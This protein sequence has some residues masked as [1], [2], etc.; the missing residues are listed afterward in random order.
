MWP[1]A[2]ALSTDNIL[3]CLCLATAC[4]RRLSR[5]ASSSAPIGGS[6]GRTISRAPTETL[7]GAGGSS[8][9]GGGG[10]AAIAGARDRH[11]DCHRPLSLRSPS[12][13]SSIALLPAKDAT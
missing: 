3:C 7:G 4:C 10:G 5:S 11:I 8:S 12:S 1:V 6:R 9:G 13:Y 2:L